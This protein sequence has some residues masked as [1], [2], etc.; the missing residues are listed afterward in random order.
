MRRFPPLAHATEFCSPTMIYQ[1]PYIVQLFSAVI[2]AKKWH[3][4]RVELNVVPR[5]YLCVPAFGVFCI[6]RWSSS[7]P[8]DSGVLAFLVRTVRMWLHRCGVVRGDLMRFAWNCCYVSWAS[9]WFWFWMTSE[10]CLTLN[11][12][13]GSSN[14]SANE[15]PESKWQS[16]LVRVWWNQIRVGVKIESEYPVRWCFSK[17]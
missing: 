4:H 5:W 11:V 12:S 3:L 14:M 8:F 2:L 1:T 16:R 13:Y 9:F 17:A 15:L 7:V 10:R 6:Y